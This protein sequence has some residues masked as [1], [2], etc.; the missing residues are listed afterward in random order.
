VIRTLHKLKTSNG[1]YSQVD[2]KIHET[3]IINDVGYP[4]SLRPA[5]GF[6]TH[7]NYHYMIRI[8]T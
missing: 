4:L 2:T 8:Q 1:I 3:Q 6:S 7:E 5:F